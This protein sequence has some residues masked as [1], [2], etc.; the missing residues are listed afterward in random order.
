MKEKTKYNL[1][2]YDLLTTDLGPTEI[3]KKYGKS[4]P[5]VSGI[6]MK[7]KRLR[8]KP[9][10]EDGL[11]KCSKC[12]DDL[13][14]NTK[15][16]VI[17]H[18]HLSGEQIAIICPKCNQKVRDYDLSD[19]TKDEYNMFFGIQ[20]QK[21]NVMTL[22]LPHPFDDIKKAVDTLFGEMYKWGSK[23]Q[24]KELKEKYQ[25]EMKIVEW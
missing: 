10:I 6:K 4:Q 19:R 13:N 18:S 21:T 24:K 20:E 7:L 17:H 11:I 16:F 23:S 12:K 15:N 1:V 22:D 14:G 5:Y 25:K 8:I 3:G 9:T 2:L